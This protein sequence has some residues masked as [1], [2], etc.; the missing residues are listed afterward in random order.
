MSFALPARSPAA[1]L[2]V[3]A[4]AVL[5]TFGLAAPAC[6]APPTS[7]DDAAPTCAAPDA[8]PT[9]V[10]LDADT[11]VENTT[12]AGGCTLND[13]LDD[14]RAWANHGRFVAHVTHVSKDLVADDELSRS[15]A[16]RLTVAAAQSD[17]GTVAGYEPLFDGTEESFEAW[18]YAGDGG[19]DYVDDG[20][21]RSRVGADG[22]FGTLWY[23][24]VEYA[25]FSLRLKFRDD[26]PG[27][28]RGNSGVQ[29]RFPELW[30]PVDG[31]P[32]TF[33][34]SETGNLSWIAVNCGHEIQIND[35]PETG[36]N[37]PRK[38]GSIYGFADL[39]L[40]QAMP[41]P[42]GTW[43]DLEI[44]VVGQ[45]YTVIRNGVVIN[46]FENLPGLPFPGRPN[47]P[48][49]SSRGLT[50]YVGL[51][52][53]GSAPDVVSFRDVRIRPLP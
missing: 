50:G 5:V 29:V 48:D 28:L 35:S 46:E 25:D 15:D 30:G 52:A 32:T 9:V 13:V 49:S 38:T 20:S 41:T 14:E 8:R 24:H 16:R 11:G 4:A 21:I 17:V 1:R 7:H 45:H 33:N 47:D 31:C 19:F 23:P 53:H 36:S 40:A 42:K 10:F 37:D 6:G 51:Q 18:A 2:S 3:T 44:R 22:G 27:D 26:A 34:G 12:L 39:N 43:N